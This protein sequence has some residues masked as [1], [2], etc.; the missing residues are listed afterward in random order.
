[1]QRERWLLLLTLVHL[2][3]ALVL[4][5]PQTVSQAQSYGFVA[6]NTSSSSKC[7]AGP[8]KVLVRIS[9]CFALDEVKAIDT[10]VTNSLRGSTSQYLVD[11]VAISVTYY[12]RLENPASPYD[13]A[14]GTVK[15][16]ASTFQSGIMGMTYDNPASP[17]ASPD[18]TIRFVKDNGELSALALEASI[19]SVQFRVCAWSCAVLPTDRVLSATNDL[20]SFDPMSFTRYI[21]CSRI[22]YAVGVAYLDANNKQQCG[23]ICPV[24]TALNNGICTS[25]L[26]DEAPTCPWNKNRPT[27]YK[28]QWSSASTSA[29]KLVSDCKVDVLVPTDNYVADRR[30][31]KNDG[32][33]PPNDPKI[34]VGARMETDSL[35]DSWLQFSLQPQLE[36][37]KVEFRA[38]GVYNVT[39]SASDY[40][41]ET[42]CDGC[43]AVVDSYPPHAVVPCA[44]ATWGSLETNPA[45]LTS[46]NLQTAISK[47]ASFNAFSSATNVV[48]N[49]PSERVDTV[50]R[51]MRDWSASS[52]AALES[53]S[54]LCFHDYIVRDLLMQ[55][56]LIQSPLTLTSTALNN[57]QCMRCCTKQTTLRE[58]Y[59]DYKCGQGSSSPAKLIAGDETCSFNHCMRITGSGLVQ[60]A[61]NA[62][63]SSS[64]TIIN[65]NSTCPTLSSSCSYL[66]NLTSLVSL[67]ASWNADLPNPDSYLK[68]FNVSSYVF[69]RYKK[70]SDNWVAWD[71]SIVVDFIDLSTTLSIQAW[72]RCGLVKQFDFTVV[73]TLS[74]TFILPYTFASRS[75]TGVT[76]NTTLLSLS[77]TPTNCASKEAML[78]FRLMSSA[79]QNAYYATTCVSSP[80]L[81]SGVSKTTNWVSVD[82]STQSS[83]LNSHTIDCG[84]GAITSF[85]LETQYQ[86]SSY[87][88][89]YN[90]ACTNSLNPISCNRA[91]LSGKSMQ[92]SA[93]YLDRQNVTCPTDMYL[94]KTQLQYDTAGGSTDTFNAWTVWYQS[95]CCWYQYATRTRVSY[96]VALPTTLAGFPQTPCLSGEAMNSFS[97]DY[98]TAS[99]T[100]TCV[101]DPRLTAGSQFYTAWFT[102]TNS[103]SIAGLVNH[104]MDCGSAA[105]NGFQLEINGAMTRY[106]YWCTKASVALST[107]TVASATSS[108]YVADAVTSLDSTGATC[109]SNYFLTK[110]QLQLSSGSPYYKATCCLRP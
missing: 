88:I 47:E 4:A 31:N 101:T 58:Y 109:L 1:M 55:P 26:A 71:D 81:T 11:S 8:L 37:D 64:P 27:G 32:L 49:G 30:L 18:A 90:Y 82:M 69:W 38:F 44:T 104:I 36:L 99:Y 95:T 73:V 6:L 13:C 86:L 25:A 75:T 105:L 42:S 96:G 103:N 91:V 17:L 39:M 35:I 54:S 34:E 51:T 66:A 77:L 80:I 87:Q 23:C 79:G 74:P 15:L 70:G 56:I 100:A 110:L 22:T 89:R 67:S 14:S 5:A 19:Y 97:Y 62:I 24:G 50:I 61:A 107:C 41:R 21:P 52:Y 59:F 83:R 108:G 63:A 10:W 102:G 76:M 92:G 28:C 53:T 43:V 98:F 2:L 16:T 20:T 46:S 40:N 48:N 7:A 84:T 12:A 9:S 45:D 68:G 60:V 85:K 65:R 57:L 94:A 72:T 29:L 93:F 106:K 78:G 33:V 3:H